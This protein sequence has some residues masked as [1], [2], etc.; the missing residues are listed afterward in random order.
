MGGPPAMALVN[1][2]AIGDK[3][4]LNATPIACTSN[5]LQVFVTHFSVNGPTSVTGNGLTWSLWANVSNVCGIWIAQGV[6]PT[7]AAMDYGGHGGSTYGLCR[8]EVKNVFVGATAAD[9]IVQ[10]IQGTNSSNTTHSATFA[11]PFTAGN[12]VLGIY[13]TAS[14]PASNPT[15]APTLVDGNSIAG[16]LYHRY[17]WPG[18]KSA[19]LIGLP[20]TTITAIRSGA[21]TAQAIGWELKAA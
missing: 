21:A 11:A 1:L 10:S 18:L 6:S 9:C 17:N 2:Y 13:N 5:A 3:S 19:D 12:G 20:N 4:T 15:W 7:T 16:D 8:F 14:V